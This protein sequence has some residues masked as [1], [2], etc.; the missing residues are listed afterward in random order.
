MRANLSWTTRYKKTKNPTAISEELGTKKQDV[1]SEGRVLNMSP[2]FNT[3]KGVSK[4]P[5]P[6]LWTDP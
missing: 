3:T 4:P 1:G 2:A 6:L 5:K